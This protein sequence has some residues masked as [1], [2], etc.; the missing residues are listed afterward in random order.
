MNL[1]GFTAENSLYKTNQKYFL[2][3][4]SSAAAGDQSGLIHPA[5]YACWRG[6]CMC[7]GD[8]DCNGMFSSA[9]SSDGYGRCWVRGPGDGNV[10]CMCN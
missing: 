2:R 5:R 7:S 3:A 8:D 9:C 4:L 10:F 1:P 6:V